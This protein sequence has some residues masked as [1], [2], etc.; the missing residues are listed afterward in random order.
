MR[1]NSKTKS[2]FSIDFMG[3]G[4]EKSATTW[5]ADCLRDHPEIFVPKEK[6]IYFFND[7]DPH[8]LSVENPKFKKGI[9]WYRKFFD[10]AD[11]K[12]KKGEFSPTYLYSKRTAR[13][14]KKFFPD[15]KIIV[16]LRNPV[17]RAFSQYLH[18]KRLGL[19]H[20]SVSF[21]DAFRENSSLEEKSLYYKYLKYYYKFFPKKNILV[22]LYDDIKIKPLKTIRGIYKFLGVRDINFRPESLSTRPL[23]ASSARVGVL[24]RFLVKGEYFLKRNRLYFLSDFLEKSRIREIAHDFSFKIN[25]KRIEKYP[26]IE[27]KLKGKMKRFFGTDIEKL[28]NLINRDLSSWR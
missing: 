15:I 9:G 2:K 22:I 24:N 14:I 25:S 21:E 13:R 16:S 27:G 1:G 26:L 17:E 5:I 7:L 12:Q 4:A 10:D 6:E 11:V 23:A 8:L 19:I 18:D 28:E 3:I 20:K